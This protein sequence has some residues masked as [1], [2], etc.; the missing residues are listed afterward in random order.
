MDEIA[1][2]GFHFL[3]VKGGLC[4]VEKGLLDSIIIRLFTVV[5]G[6]LD[7]DLSASF[8]FHVYADMCFIYGL[9]DAS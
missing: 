8:L 7:T 6:S 2:M 9:Y 5:L 4:C 1:A 3:I